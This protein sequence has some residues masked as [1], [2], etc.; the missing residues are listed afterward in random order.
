MR[1]T[2][3]ARAGGMLAML[4]AALLL[5]PQQ[6]AQAWVDSPLSYEYSYSLGT[7]FFYS[8]ESVMAGAASKFVD[9]FPF[10]VDCG[11]FAQLPPKHEPP[12][13]CNLPTGP[14]LNPLA[15]TDRT[16][17]TFQFTSLPGH[18]EGPDRKIRF[19][20][21]K[22]SDQDI[23][24]NV[25]GWGPFTAEAAG[26]IQSGAVKQMWQSYANNLKAYIEAGILNGVEEKSEREAIT[27]R[28]LSCGDGGITEAN[29][30]FEPDSLKMLAGF[31]GSPGAVGT[32]EH[33][34]AAG[35]R[36]ADFVAAD[37][38]YPNTRAA[39]SAGLLSCI[40]DLKKKFNDAI[41]AGGVFVDNRY[42]VDATTGPCF[43][44][45]T[46]TRKCQLIKGFG[47][48]LA[49]IHDF[50]LRSNYTDKA[51]PEFSVTNPPGLGLHAPSGLFN[52]LG[53]APTAAEIPNDLTMGCV[54]ASANNYCAAATPMGLKGRTQHEYLEKDRGEIAPP[55]SIFIGHPVSVRG[56]TTV[57]GRSNF[58]RAVEASIAE[59]TEQWKDFRE[60]LRTKYGA[61]RGN[62]IACAMTHDDA[63][64]CQ[65]GPMGAGIALE[66]P[67]TG[68]FTDVGRFTHGYPDSP[69]GPSL[70]NSFQKLMGEAKRLAEQRSGDPKGDFQVSV[71]GFADQKDAAYIDAFITHN[72]WFMTSAWTSAHNTNPLYGPVYSN[73]FPGYECHEG[74]PQAQNIST[75]AVGQHVFQVAY[76]CSYAL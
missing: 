38:F 25:E 73:G 60:Q 23:R 67:A 26:S 68:N 61:R 32:A 4:T 44:W 14:F 62:E 10:E 72:D 34:T 56:Q 37:P 39:A 9:T 17:T 55:P 65:P 5:T 1:R 6:Q 35:C 76:T 19:S 49:G 3:K 71:Y 70:E 48:E 51:E 11:Q 42:K 43:S 15:V 50:Y 24:L 75:P 18:A 63:M 31:G 13:K 16:A 59:T 46:Q 53:T 52:M 57:D 66:D 33:D 36:D 20:F 69:F 58:V 45:T 2:T 12:Y 21:S 7:S 29:D 27:R 28:A 8:P 47:Q 40:G 41:T 54:P 74:G 22:T 64:R 30:C